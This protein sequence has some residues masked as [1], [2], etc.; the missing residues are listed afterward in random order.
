MC[1]HSAS[2][3]P[4]EEHI[5]LLLDGYERPVDGVESWHESWVLD[6]LRGNGRGSRIHRCMGGGGFERSSGVE[7]GDRARHS[8]SSS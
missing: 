4:F 3:G 1:G 5:V 6:W 8:S 7:K 2:S